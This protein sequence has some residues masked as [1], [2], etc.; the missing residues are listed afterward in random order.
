MVKGKIG[1]TSN[2]LKVLW[3]WLQFFQGIHFR[4]ISQ[5]GIT[6]S[7]R[8]KYTQHRRDFYSLV[9]SIFMFHERNCGI[10][11]LQIT[12][13]NNKVRSSWAFLSSFCKASGNVLQSKRILKHQQRI[14][15]TAP[16]RTKRYWTKVTKFFGGDEKFCQTKILSDKVLSDKIVRKLVKFVLFDSAFCIHFS[17][18]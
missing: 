5:L 10:K 12:C 4:F 17:F 14:E 1:K 18:F 3:K 13:L 2:S 9:V 11:E 15:R 16:Y 8:R 7:Q 6:K